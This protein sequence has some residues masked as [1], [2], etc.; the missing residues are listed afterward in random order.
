MITQNYRGGR[1]RA[2]V[3]VQTGIGTSELEFWSALSL[4]STRGGGT[5]NAFTSTMRGRAGP[6]LG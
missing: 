2:Q 5:V 4:R 6:H 3:L 1:L